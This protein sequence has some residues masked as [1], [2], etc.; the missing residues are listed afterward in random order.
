MLMLIGAYKDTLNTHVYEYSK[1]EGAI[2]IE[3]E[4]SYTDKV[5]GVLGTLLAGV[6]RGRDEI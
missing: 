3:N 6:I 1:N 5:N 4:Y 2:K